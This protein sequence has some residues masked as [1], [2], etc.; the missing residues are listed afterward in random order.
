MTEGTTILAAYLPIKDC[1][2]M[3][4]ASNSHSILEDYAS[5]TDDPS[6]NG[7]VLKGATDS[8]EKVG[9]KTEVTGPT[10]EKVP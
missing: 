8:R 9:V 4:R 7:N 1:D 6:V 5:P 3:A 10:T 2:H